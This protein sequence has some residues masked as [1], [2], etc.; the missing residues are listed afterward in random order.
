MP[1][2]T[3]TVTIQINLAAP[4]VVSG[5]RVGPFIIH[6][7]VRSAAYGPVGKRAVSVTPPCGWTVGTFRDKTIAR[8]LATELAA[9]P[10][11]NWDSTD[12]ETVFPDQAAKRAAYDAVRAYRV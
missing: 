5:E 2:A 9:L 1:K 12:S 3:G 8:R 11:V 7:P 4:K 6:A 10:G